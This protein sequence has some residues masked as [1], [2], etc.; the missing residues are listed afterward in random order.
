MVAF[1]NGA[2]LLLPGLLALVGCAIAHFGFQVGVAD[3]G[4]ALVMVGAGIKWLVSPF[5]VLSSL[6][7]PV[8][9]VQSE[10]LDTPE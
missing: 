6:L 7:L 9:C 2:G 8:G 4:A 3:S 5:P 1:A 10:S